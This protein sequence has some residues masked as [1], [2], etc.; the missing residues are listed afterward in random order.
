MKIQAEIRSFSQLIPVLLFWLIFPFGA[1]AQEVFVRSSDPAIEELLDELASDHVIILN[2]VIKPYSREFI[3][4]S[5]LTALQRDSLLSIR[6]RNEIRLYLKNFSPEIT[7]LLR[8]EMSNIKNVQSG[9]TLFDYNPLGVMLNGSNTDFALRPVLGYQQFINNHTPVS[10][11]KAGAAALGYIGKHLGIYGNV[12][13]NFETQVLSNS[14][15]FML[16]DGGKWLCHSNGSGNYIDWTGQVTWSWKWGMVGMFNDRIDWGTNYHGANILASKPPAFPFLKLRIHPAT[17]I[18]FSY[19][20][21]QLVSNVLDSSRTYYNDPAGSSEIYL[22]KFIAANMLTITPWKYLNIS[23]G[24]SIIYDNHF[25]VAYLIPVLFYKSVD[26]TLSHGIDNENSQMF[27]DISSRQ[28]KHLH[29]FLTLFIDELMFSRI[30]HADQN[31]FLSW[32]GG[33]KLSDLPLRNVSLTCEYTRTLPMT[34]QHYIPTLTFE[35]DSYT[36]GN[37][38][39]DNSQELFVSIEYRPISRLSVSLVCIFAE[40]G[41]NYKYGVEPDPVRLPVLKNITWKN[42]SL[43]FE[44]RFTLTS[45]TSCFLSYQYRETTGDNDFTPPLFRG[46]TNTLSFGFQTGF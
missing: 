45:N 13:E 26:H 14:N 12:T 4:R 43:E 30:Q 11:V 7:R 36:L 8:T 5:L 27:M 3:A 38:I 22:K 29:L 19:I 46:K 10:S 1:T 20:H 21:G 34:Y 40:H 25:Q 15:Y 24:N 33:F 18:E 28:I 39:K 35:S 44:G 41:D 23:V 42:Q 32:K 2:S 9:S 16:R 37:Y 31:N 6:Q 17:W